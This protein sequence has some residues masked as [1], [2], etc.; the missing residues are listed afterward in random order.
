M[1]TQSI[2][3]SPRP[4]LLMM[5]AALLL[6]LCASVSCGMPL[7]PMCHLPRWAVS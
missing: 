7:L 3:T 2:R 1:K 4:E 5:K 6:V